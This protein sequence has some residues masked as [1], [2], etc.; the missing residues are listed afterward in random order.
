VASAGRC[1]Q[2][3][4]FAAAAA[5]PLPKAS[6]WLDMLFEVGQQL[7]LPLTVSEAD[8]HTSEQTVL[9]LNSEFTKL[10]GYTL[11]MLKSKQLGSVLDGE[12][13]EFWAQRLL[14]E[15]LRRGASQTVTITTYY[16]NGK[17]VPNCLRLQPVWNAQGVHQYTLGLQ[18]EED[19][20]QHDALFGQLLN[21]LPSRIPA[22][23]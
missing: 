22:G 12:H 17:Y 20:V 9:F 7:R 15:S 14:R 6:S 8:E 13:T 11:D 3:D 21:M 10:T 23:L 19:N 16:R 2:I 1:P 5:V 18:F 4:A